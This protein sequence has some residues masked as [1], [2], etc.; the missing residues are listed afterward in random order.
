MLIAGDDWPAG[1]M[2]KAWRSNGGWLK[3]GGSL[4]GWRHETM[5]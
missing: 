2:S 3:P 1:G 4:P 5:A